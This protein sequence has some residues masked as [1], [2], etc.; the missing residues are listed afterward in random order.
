MAN[1]KLIFPI[2]FDLEEGV[3]EASKEWKSTYHKQLQK[4]IDDKPLKVKIDFE[5][6]GIDTKEFKQWMALS[7]EAE[8]LERERIKNA[9]E[10]Q[11]VADQAAMAE[12]RRAN[13]VNESNARIERQNRKA[14]ASERRKRDA[15]ERTNEAY[16]RQGGYLQRL[17]QRMVAYASVTQAFSFI[18]NIREVTAQFELQRVALGSIIG[19]L[20]EA[21]AMFEQIK[22]AAVKS[23]FQIK[24]LVTYTKQ[25]AAYK[26]ESDELFETTQRLADISA[27]LGVGMER[28]VLAYGQI[29][30]TGYLR[31]SEVRQLTEAG[32]PI[33]EELAKKMSQ[34]RG[35]TVS[36][37]EVMGLI[38]ERA[39]SFGM[40][41]E[42]FDDMTSA[43]GMFYKM[44]EKQAET[45]AGQ[46]SNLQDAI[47]IMYE[48][49]GNT[50]GANNSIKGTIG[51]VKSLAENWRDV[52]GVVQSLSVAMGVYYVAMKNA[53]VASKALTIA[54]ATRLAIENKQMIIIPKWLAFFDRK[55]RLY[56]VSIALEKALALAQLKTA[57]ATNVLS[58]SFW[59]LTT[60]M[61]SNP[62]TAVLAALAG[63][64]FAI[65]KFKT[66]TKTAQE[67]IDDLNK[68]VASFNEL[69]NP[70]NGVRKLIDELDALSQKANK[71][72]EE[73][74]R[75][76]QVTRALAE[77]Y[78]SA[79][80]GVKEYGQEV[81]VAADKVKELYESELKLRQDRIRQELKSSEEEYAKLEALYNDYISRINKGT[82]LQ[83]VV[84]P[85]TDEVT[86]YEKAYTE[87]ELEKL[88]DKA[89]EIADK[90]H[91]L[92]TTV[93]NAKI[94]LGELKDEGE[95]AVDTFNTWQKELMTIAEGKNLEGVA[96]RIF[97]DETI[98]QTPKLTSAL[99]KVA[100]KYKKLKEEKA[101]VDKALKSEGAKA[102][103]QTYA[104][105][106]ERL[107][108][109]NE[110]M[111]GL[112]DF[113][114]KY[115]GIDL[116]KEDGKS[117]LSILQEELQLH[118]KIYAKYKE[119]RKYMNEE[120]AKKKVSE[121]FKDTIGD[122]KFTPS[123]DKDGY[124]NVLTQYQGE[125]KALLAKAKDETERGAIKKV[126]LDLGFKIDDIDW[127]DEKDEIEKELKQLSDDLSRTK[128][129]KEF[130][131]R[132]LGLTGDKQLSATLTMSVYGENAD[133]LGGKLAQQ[134]IDGFK[135]KYEGVD[136]SKEAIS[137][138]GIFNWNKIFEEGKSQK[139]KFGDT[140]YEQFLKDVDEGKKA[141]AVRVE[142]LIRELDK[143]KSYG[144]KL[145]KVYTNTQERINEINK[146]VA[147]KSMRDILTKQAYDLQTKEMQKLQY[148][149]FKE[150]PMF[151]AMFENLD[152]TSTAML[153]SMRSHILKLQSEWKNLDF[154]QLKELQN[155]INE[156]DKQ[157]AT[158]NPF[159]GII[160]GIKEFNALQKSGSR[161]DDEQA[162][163][164]AV[165]KRAE[166]QA[167][168]DKAVK[169]GASEEQI[170]QLAIDLDKCV[171]AE[172]KADAT[173]KVVQGVQ[174]LSQVT[175]LV[176][177]TTAAVN[178]IVEAFDS[179]GDSAD[180]E[181]WN[182]ILDGVNSLMNGVQSAGTGITQI[183]TGNILGGVTSLVSSIGSIASSIGNLIYAGRI[184]DAN[185]E[186][187]R[188]QELLDNLAY[189]YERLGKAQEK[190]FGAD[191]IAIS[192][193]RLANLRAQQEAYLKQAEAERSKGKKADEAKIKEYEEQVRDTANAIKDMQ[194]ELSEH[195]LGTDL[196][197]AAR[198][199]AQ[200]WIDAY[201]EFG[202]TADAMKD[203]FKDM[204]ENMIVESFAAK[205]IQTAL[206]PIFDS[207]DNLTKDGVLD[208]SD[209]AKIAEMTDVAVGNIDVGMTNLMNALS[210]AGLS[211]RGMGSNLTGISRDIATASEESILGLAAGINTQNF[212][213][214]QVPPKLD[215]IIGLLRGG[216]L[217]QGSTITL[218]DL[219]TL[220]NQHLSY[221]P[222]IAQHT[223]ETVTQCQRAADACE[224][225]VKQLGSVIKPNGTQT[226]YKLNATLSRR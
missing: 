67:R 196:T 147:D 199:F 12:T 40:V 42:V 35:E 34:L 123:F 171:D 101:Q 160:D 118:E 23:P 215:T 78:P 218:Q 187:E 54:E 180:E 120:E 216:G 31:A 81:G 130:F 2:G 94:A 15:V 139:G 103:K 175:D 45:L 105:L 212:Y 106:E 17:F 117:Q 33:V 110:G 49:I 195:F 149:A 145:I 225:M 142:S 104:Q 201:K 165:T 36:A 73:Q 114:K 59:K 11:K 197:S 62:Y 122:L 8:K 173:K 64:T 21:N 211:V 116:I 72:T 95:N 77:S 124:K 108:K 126:L 4:A 91:L 188:Q 224:T 48:E 177:T 214:S 38:S 150:S 97:D 44:Q 107:G 68:S 161:K 89:L 111:S 121:Y 5:S 50:E 200:A 47:S 155:R 198:D 13:A 22:A 86:Y 55:N 226:A 166:A 6:K 71:T 210:Q 164:D 194:S 24:E 10:W 178:D 7:R 203:K 83:P 204:I 162:L 202:S 76:N 141:S 30:A 3:K 143:T 181:F 167:K 75:L 69:S 217:T 92:A 156:I 39:I 131:D 182:T 109:I 159:K 170:K 190:A 133:E 9:R 1:D 82:Y 20:N 56:K 88:G 148:D 100:E 135:K 96:N 63:I 119:Y 183:M 219:M 193:Q 60:A 37:A 112:Y 27:G 26:I 184:Q 146:E 174:S 153:T 57:T 169:D 157:V 191:Y 221:L 205:V 134:T 93:K 128:A 85:N 28:L 144:E 163:L 220:Q 152:A 90:M 213:I 185:K 65:V 115:G 151:V 132:M 186:I 192:E 43:G 18:R 206:Q 136:F 222:T 209:A 58:K 25:L 61:L 179:W 53:A 176:Q 74:K 70:K 29:R 84:N 154:T 16:K 52:W 19:D 113:L 98:A 51:L 14:E 32:I 158:R 223:A 66:K 129:A 46:W 207:I 102:D 172:K 208:V 168:Y 80:N 87:K 138:K 99:E 140:E 125:I 41:K 137:D 79:I 127:K 189:S